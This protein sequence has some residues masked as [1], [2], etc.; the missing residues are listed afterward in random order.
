M[1]LSYALATGLTSG[2][3][4]ALVAVGLVMVYKATGV[5]NIAHGELFMFA[6]FIAYAAHVQFGLPYGIAC[7]LAAA[8]AFG[9]GALVYQ[10]AFKSLMKSSLANVL[11]AAI[12][13]SFILKGIA[14]AVWGGIGDYIP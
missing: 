6:G 13:V 4:Y 2:A 1:L 14:R 8:A 5:I 3:L 10:G 11:I 7:L 12:A 9:L